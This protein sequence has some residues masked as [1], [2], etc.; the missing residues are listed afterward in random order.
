MHAGWRRSGG[1]RSEPERSRQPARIVVIL[2]GE[3][4]LVW[5]RQLVASVR[6]GASLRAAAGRYRCSV[7]TAWTWVQRARNRRLDRVDWSDRPRGRPGPV[8]RTARRIERRIVR[9]RRRLARSD[10]LGYVGPA[11]LR[12]TLLA[13]GQA[14]PCAR[15]IAR[16]LQRAG[17]TP[18][19]RRRQPPPPSGWYLP[20]VAR[21]EA[22]LD[23][24]DVVEGLH[25]HGHGPVEALTGISLWGKLA[26]AEPA[27]TGWRTATITPV[28]ARH[29]R[30]WGVPRCLQTDNDT[31][32]AGSSRAARRLS[33]FVRFCLR[34]GVV[35]VFVPPRET[36][37]QAAIEN[38]NGLWQAKVWQRFR[39]RDLRQLRARNRAFVAAHRRWTRREGPVRH[40]WPA[41]P[42]GQVVFLRRTDARG[43][44]RLLGAECAVAPHWPHRLVR[45][46]LDVRTQTV[47]LYALRR[48]APTHQPLL[49][50]VRFRL[51]GVA[52]F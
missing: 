11:A 27:S 40:R 26:L 34:H 37:F 28:L 50:T 25:L 52:T 17:V 43:H 10:P 19:R 8:N 12:R 42:A 22:E 7:G 33:R 16:I 23:Q 13:A 32:F 31:R 18:Q 15:T 6:R 21:G 46:E 24:L 9:L 29:W 36:G 38:F 3:K 30:R 4:K 44:I 5:R 41:V 47:R 20:R 39:H 35:P 51:R 49:K 14:A 1:E 45:A 48:R 2:R